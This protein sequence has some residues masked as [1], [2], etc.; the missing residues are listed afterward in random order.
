[1]DKQ[2]IALE[3]LSLGYSRQVSRA[4]T[5]FSSFWDIFFG[6]SI[7][8]LGLIIGMKEVGFAEYN[9]PVFIILAILVL[10]I[11]GLV[12]VI[13]FIFWFIS[14]SEREVIKSKLLLLAS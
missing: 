5:I 6:I 4:H 1:M 2:Q 3:I 10:M 12:G 7:G 14:R 8:F 9:T 11:V 13:A